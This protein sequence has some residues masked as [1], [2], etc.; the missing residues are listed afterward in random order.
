MPLSW[1]FV[2]MQSYSK[3]FVSI[4]Q[5]HSR[6]L[7]SLKYNKVLENKVPQKKNIYIPFCLSLQSNAGHRVHV[8]ACPGPHPVHCE[9]T[10]AL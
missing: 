5:V 2:H 3:T 7:Y 6:L 1:D 9:E 10:A 8:T 4:F